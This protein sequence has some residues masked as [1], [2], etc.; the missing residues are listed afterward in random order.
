MELPDVDK[1]MPQTKAG[2]KK[3]VALDDVL[4]DPLEEAAE[5]YEEALSAILGELHCHIMTC[6]PQMFTVFMQL[7][8]CVLEL[9]GAV[10]WS[11]AT[12]GLDLEMAV[13]K[14][15][16]LYALPWLLGHDSDEDPQDV[17]LCSRRQLE[18]MAESGE[19]L[20]NFSEGG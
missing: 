16:G 12:Q 3:H 18:G 2:P 6:Q 10:H 5:L 13:C 8:D 14:H 20:Q 9:I 11:F 17:N 4:H 15:A 1:D 19:I 7:A